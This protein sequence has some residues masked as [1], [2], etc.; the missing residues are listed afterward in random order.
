MYKSKYVL[1]NNCYF[2]LYICNQIFISKMG[3]VNGLITDIWKI[4]MYPFL[5]RT[6]CPIDRKLKNIYKHTHR[7]TTQA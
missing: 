6:I 2:I 3:C 4:S 7:A 1:A 5:L